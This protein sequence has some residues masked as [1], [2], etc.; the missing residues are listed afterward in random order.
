[1]LPYWVFTF[2]SPLF[3]VIIMPESVLV[4]QNPRNS[5]RNQGS[6]NASAWWITSISQRFLEDEGFLCYQISC[7]FWSWCV[8]HDPSFPASLTPSSLQHLS[9]ILQEGWS[10]PLLNE[11][12]LVFEQK[13]QLSNIRYVWNEDCPEWILFSVANEIHECVSW[14]LKTI[15]L[16]NVFMYPKFVCQWM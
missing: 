9:L 4:C 3:F 6:N 12:V 8:T 14:C 5:K 2:F 16:W 7:W 11:F 1:M 13:E 15:Y 10:K